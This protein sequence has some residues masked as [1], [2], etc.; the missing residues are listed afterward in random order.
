[1]HAP[2]DQPA[3]EFDLCDGIALMSPELSAVE[4]ASGD[5]DMALVPAD[6]TNQP[7]PSGVSNDATMGS[8]VDPPAAA[9]PVPPV[10][11]GVLDG[12][13]PGGA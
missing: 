9:T 3:E 2:P 4:E 12:G 8:A 6:T 10:A 7:D 13:A 11:D 1:M 5:A